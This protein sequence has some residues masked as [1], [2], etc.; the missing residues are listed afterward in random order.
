MAA[1]AL[2]GSE[3]AMDNERNHRHSDPCAEPLCGFRLVRC[4]LLE[5]LLVMLAGL[6]IL[7]FAWEAGFF[8]L[9]LVLA[10]LIWVGI[11]P[12]IDVATLRHRRH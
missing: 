2:H 1:G 9:G 8:K 4:L 6:L 12:I 5:T 11:S 3:V 7:G 10:V